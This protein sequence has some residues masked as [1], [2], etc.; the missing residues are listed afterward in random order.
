MCV[1]LVASPSFWPVRGMA[2]RITDFAEHSNTRTSHTSLNLQNKYFICR[3]IAK[4]NIYL[5]IRDFC[6]TERKSHPAMSTLC[7]QILP[8]QASVGGP[9]GPKRE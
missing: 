7:F 8:S 2:H 3:L 5:R 4:Y 9:D 6:V 1:F